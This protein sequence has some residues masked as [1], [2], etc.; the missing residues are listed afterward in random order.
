MRAPAFARFLRPAAPTARLR[1]AVLAPPLTP[2]LAAPL[3]PAAMSA[4]KLPCA[5]R[6]RSRPRVLR[7]R[8]RSLPGRRLF[9]LQLANPE[10]S[11]SDD[12]AGVIP[13]SVVYTLPSIPSRFPFP[14]CIPTALPCCPSSPSP[15]PPSTPPTHSPLPTHYISPARSP[16][17]TPASWLQP[18]P[19]DL[20]RA[21]AHLVG[22]SVCGRRS[23][24][25]M[26]GLSG[27]RR[28]MPPAVAARRGRVG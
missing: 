21:A 17:Q 12:G 6:W 22:A 18:Q 5:R 27:G 20:L 11:V 26:M 4:D 2:S 1:R 10:V 8:A 24:S 3:F 25:S 23:K 9:P 7:A 28:S 13:R 16:T 14:P 15:S 19:P